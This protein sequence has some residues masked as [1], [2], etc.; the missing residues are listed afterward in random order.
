MF[1]AIVY[2]NHDDSGPYDS[3][4]DTKG[5]EAFLAD[6]AEEAAAKAKLWADRWQLTPKVQPV[7][8][9]PA[10]GTNKVPPPKY[11]GPYTILVGEVTK[12][13]KA[14]EV[15]LEKFDDPYSF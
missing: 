3:H 1:V 2:I 14:I 8:Y 15:E 13:A 9:D 10:T 5:W 6:T 11:C 4:R 12:Q 7:Q